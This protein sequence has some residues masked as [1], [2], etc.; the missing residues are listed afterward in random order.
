MALLS[1]GAGR[2]QTVLAGAMASR[3]R[4]PRYTPAMET[5]VQ[6]KIT[7]NPDRS[8][9]V[10]SFMAFSLLKGRVVAA[11]ASA[12]V[13][14]LRGKRLSLP[15]RHLRRGAQ[16]ACVHAVGDGG[17]IAG[18]LLGPFNGGAFGALGGAKEIQVVL[19][20]ARDDHVEIQGALPSLVTAGIGHRKVDGGDGG[21]GRFGSQFFD[22]CKHDV[23]LGW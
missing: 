10:F 4:A 20:R 6:R 17:E 3:A 11:P 7:T 5:T 14:D 21:R 13:L 16:A 23:L 8:C 15:N 2:S 12:E 9:F 22:V 1:A 18:F 19:Q